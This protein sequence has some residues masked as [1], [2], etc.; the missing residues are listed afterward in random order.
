MRQ[1]ITIII[2]ALL[3]WL[4]S[5]SFAW[6]MVAVIPFLIAVVWQQRAGWAFV[7]GF[8][9]IGLLWL[10]LILRMDNANEQLL[11]NRM[12]QLFGLGYPPFT[13][14]NILLGALIGG[15]GGWSGA[16]MWK[17]FKQKGQA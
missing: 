6:W 17:L 12:A 14:V 1:L 15:L 16:S 10:Y 13:A 11:S 8:I 3:A 7:N 2:T 9:S 4:A 5:Y